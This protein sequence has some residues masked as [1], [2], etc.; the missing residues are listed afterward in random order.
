MMRRI[1]YCSL[2]DT[3]I[4]MK[5]YQKWEK[6]QRS[7]LFCVKLKPGSHWG[8][9]RFRVRHHCKNVEIFMACIFFSI[10]SGKLEIVKVDKTRIVEISWESSDYSIETSPRVPDQNNGTT[11]P[12]KKVGTPSKFS[13]PPTYNVDNHRWFC[14]LFVEKR[15]QFPTLIGGNKGHMIQLKCPNYFCMGL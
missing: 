1:V 13:L 15:Q 2:F 14:A 11:I 4:S 9:L 7:G 3:S 6:D 12:D 5:L 8:F 10:S